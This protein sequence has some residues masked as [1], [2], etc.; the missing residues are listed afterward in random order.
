[1][2]F[3]ELRRL[4]RSDL[5]RYTGEISYHHYIVQLLRNP[6]FQYSF[7]MR[8]CK[9]AKHK[10]FLLF[11]VA[12]LML[13]HYAC[14]YGILVS[15]AADIGSGFYIGH[16]GCIVVNKDC[17]IGKNC[18]ISQGVTIG[19]ANRGKRKGTPVLG[20]SVYI[21][22]GAKIIGAVKIG[23]NVAIGANSVI[24]TDIPDNAVVVGIPAKVISYQGT[25]G[26][27]NREYREELEKPAEVS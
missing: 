25:V 21:G 10:N 11:L 15:Y 27:V 26:Y 14:K 3:G 13:E 18:N 17:K 19:Q 22:P 20:D 1:M 16:F 9:Y 6:G 23:N 5:F 12:K 24:T 2:T 4:I 7:Y 8:I